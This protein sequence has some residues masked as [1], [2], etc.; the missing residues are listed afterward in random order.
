MKA[1][2]SKKMRNF[3]LILS[4]IGPGIITVNAGN[5][6]GGIYTYAY[7][8]SKYGYKMLWGLLLIIDYL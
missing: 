3:F 7:V 5:D 2:N 6:A 1:I 4:I 8:G